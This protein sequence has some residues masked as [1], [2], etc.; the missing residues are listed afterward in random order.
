VKT[1]VGLESWW[2]DVR[3]AA[4]RG[5]LSARP[6]MPIVDLSLD[7]RDD[8]ISETLVAVVTDGEGEH[9][10]SLLPELARSSDQYS[11]VY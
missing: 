6:R 2:I 4:D 3:E 7:A 11:H 8:L 5:Q 9:S 1:L 10:D